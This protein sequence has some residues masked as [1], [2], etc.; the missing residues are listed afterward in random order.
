MLFSLSTSGATRSHQ[1]L[2]RPEHVDQLLGAAMYI[3]L[4]S[5]ACGLPAVV[6]GSFSVRFQRTL[7][8]LQHL[9]AALYRR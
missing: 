5:G 1:P 4:M 8:A 2:L 7:A 6:S 3:S 9:A